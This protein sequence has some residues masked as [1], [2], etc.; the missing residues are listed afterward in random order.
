MTRE[1]IYQVK[2]DV[3]APLGQLLVVGG[4]AMAN[5]HDRAAKLV[6]RKL[7]GRYNPQTSP[8]VKGK[9]GRAEVKSSVNEI[10]E[11]LR[12]LGGG[13]GSAF[14][15]LPGSQQEKALKRMTGLNR[16]SPFQFAMRHPDPHYSC[17]Q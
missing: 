8:D 14:V 4:I 15:V 7:R 16:H 11:A 1:S 3:I 2:L 12:Q 9:G 5:S 17:H 10:P 13:S 6:A